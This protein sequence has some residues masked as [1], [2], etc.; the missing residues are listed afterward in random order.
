MGGHKVD[1]AE[2]E[3]RLEVHPAVVATRVFGRRNSVSGEILCAEVVSRDPSLTESDLRLYLG[4]YLHPAKI[5]RVMR[6][7][8][9]IAVTRSGKR[10]RS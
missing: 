3:R 9:Q 6:F 7:V 5:P 4:A 10:L 1:P 8:D 2:V